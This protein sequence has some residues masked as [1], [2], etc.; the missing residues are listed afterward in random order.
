MAEKKKK[1]EK[2]K[3]GKG[4]S[5]FMKVILIIE[6]V[7]L[8]FAVV[9]AI[10]V[11]SHSIHQTNKENK[12][13]KRTTE[14]IQKK[15]EPEIKIKKSEIPEI[16]KQYK[17][18]CD[19]YLDTAS[20]TDVAF[21]ENQPAKQREKEQKEY[22]LKTFNKYLEL[23]ELTLEYEQWRDRKEFL[24]DFIF[25]KVDEKKAIKI[26]AE[27]T[28]R[29]KLIIK[30]QEI[31]KNKLEQAK[32]ES[33]DYIAHFVDGRPGHKTIKLAKAILIST[34][35]GF[36]FYY[37]EADFYFDLGSIFKSGKH[38]LSSLFKFLKKGKLK[39][40]V[41]KL[42]KSTK[43]YINA[44]QKEIK[45]YQVTAE[46]KENKEG[47]V[48]KQ[49]MKQAMKFINSQKKE[50]SKSSKSE[51]ER[52][53]KGRALMLVAVN[54]LVKSWEGFPTNRRHGWARYPCDTM[55]EA[56]KE[57][58]RIDCSTY[59]K[60]IMEA[61]FPKV[62]KRYPRIAQPL[63]QDQIRL[64][65][66]FLGINGGIDEFD[67]SKAFAIYAGHGHMRLMFA[68]LD[69]GD[70]VDFAVIKIS[71]ASGGSVKNRIVIVED[72]YEDVLERTINVSDARAVK[73]WLSN[74]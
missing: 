61:L 65:A 39:T 1:E 44:L 34:D 71:E 23:Y 50:L 47:E 22:L 64:Y 59:I 58:K 3:K 55:G 56:E 10:Y 69:L 49:K 19:F 16:K 63:P 29:W 38:E 66:K 11:I 15:K 28:R 24:S 32:Y 33:R 67:E 53:E 35:S 74:N 57:Y 52:I 6:A 60:R 73:K 8:A 48:I 41:I 14:K 18:M 5:A 12:E 9:F 27:L 13:I 43:D 36:H 40:I 68:D 70:N 30:I 4:M 72:E 31:L 26:K 7:G 45:K 46:N 51:K 2:K 42:P 17:E 54:Y 62:N 25:G 37:H 21:D 20:V